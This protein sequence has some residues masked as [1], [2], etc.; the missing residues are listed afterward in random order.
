MYPFQDQVFDLVVSTPV[1][2]HNNSEGLRRT[3]LEISRVLKLGAILLAT[4]PTLKDHRFVNSKRLADNTYEFIQ[5]G[6]NQKGII[7]TVAEF[8]R[9]VREIFSPITNIQVGYSEITMQGM[10]NSHWLV[11][12]FPEATMH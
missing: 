8:E 9:N 12:A 3:I 5:D 11:A 1:V 7:I 4:F 2:S 6:S 10:T